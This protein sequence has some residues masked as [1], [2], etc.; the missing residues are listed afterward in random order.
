MALIQKQPIHE[1]SEYRGVLLAQLGNLNPLPRLD[2]PLPPKPLRHG[3][4][5]PVQGHLVPGLHQPVG[6]RQR[7]VKDRVVGEVAHG[8]VVDPAQRARMAHPGRVYP[9]HRELARKHAISLREPHQIGS[10]SK[11]ELCSLKTAASVSGVLAG[12]A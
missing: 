9:L 1:T 7:I 2:I 4:L 3:R 12:I 8:K 6:H 10:G 11:V 5:Q